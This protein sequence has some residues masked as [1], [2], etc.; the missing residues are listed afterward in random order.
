MNIACDIWLD[1]NNI[2][3]DILILVTPIFCRA[4]VFSD[5]YCHNSGYSS[6]TSS[7]INESISKDGVDNI[8][9]MDEYIS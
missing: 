3:L 7:Y 6:I 2:T 5:K 4:T 9:E 1:I 8:L